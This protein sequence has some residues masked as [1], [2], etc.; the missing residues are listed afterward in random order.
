MIFQCQ[1]NE[2]FFNFS[3]HTDEQIKQRF[4]EIERKYTTIANFDAN[5]NEIS[6]SF[7]SLT[8]TADL[9]SPEETKLHIL[10]LGSFFDTSP[11]GRELTLNLARHVIAGYTIQEPP[12][13]RLLKNS[14]FHFVPFTDNFEFILGQYSRNESVC[15]PITREEFSDRLLSPEFDKKKSVFLNMLESN[16]FDL[17]LTFSAGGF[18]IQGPLTNDPNSI[19]I[20]TAKKIAESHLR[21]THTECALNPLRIHQTSTLQKITEFLL[22]SYK[23]PLYSLQVSCCKM[24]PQNKKGDVWR[25]TIHKAVNFL[26]LTE[27][28]VKG[29]IR[30]SQG[31]LRQSHV[32]V[33]GQGLTIPVTKN[34]AYFRLVLPAGQY[35]LQI[36]NNETGIQTLPINLAEGQLLDLGTILL[37]QN[38][39]A[40][41]QLNGHNIGKAGVKATTFGGKLSGVILDERNHPIK[42]AQVYLLDYKDK[43]KNTSDAMGKFE[44]YDTPFGS[45]NIKVDAYGLE[46][47]ARFVNLNKLITQY[48][49][50]QFNFVL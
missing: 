43:I 25:H 24:P 46:S 39:A 48:Q 38:H 49:L 31:P 2:F 10:V 45:V 34:M 26:K 1:I 30:D 28:G 36:N 23:L 32:T 50:I 37:T 41:Y 7:P 14:V 12:Y 35:D 21:E 19:Y 29:S 33:V 44:L 3:Y 20:K 40:R 6:M 13:V 9:G 18:D 42:G 5:E 16:R 4:A 15:D 27:T 22:N 11:L 17:A 8:V 47:A